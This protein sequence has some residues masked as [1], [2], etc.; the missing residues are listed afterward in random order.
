VYVERVNVEKGGQAI[1]GPVN[2]GGRG[3]GDDDESER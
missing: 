1:V 2:L 3:G